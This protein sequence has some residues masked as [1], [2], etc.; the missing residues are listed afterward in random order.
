MYHVTTNKHHPEFWSDNP[1]IDINN[2]DKSKAIVDATKMPLTYVACMCADWMG[3]SV[4][5]K[6]SPYEWAEKNV[7][8]RWKFTHEQV[9]FI[10][11]LY[12]LLI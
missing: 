11:Y 7:N 4:E 3:M 10:Y 5:F 8:K 1:N 12:Y 2:R 9:S 6:N